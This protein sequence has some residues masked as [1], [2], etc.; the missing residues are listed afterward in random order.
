MVLQKTVIDEALATVQI[1]IA[2][3]TAQQIWRDIGRV[4]HILEHDCEELDE[5]MPEEACF[6]M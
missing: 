1:L 2:T 4:A 6:C 3:E 5:D